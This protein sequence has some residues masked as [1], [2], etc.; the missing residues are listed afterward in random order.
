MS[1]EEKAECWVWWE[2]QGVT[3]SFL[4]SINSSS[5]MISGHSGVLGSDYPREGDYLVLPQAG[6]K[7]SAD[8]LLL[9]S[10]STREAS[11][12]VPS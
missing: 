1:W 8:A 11:V 7:R 6:Q 12:R 3:C 10:A 5:T 4:H 9:G 2:I